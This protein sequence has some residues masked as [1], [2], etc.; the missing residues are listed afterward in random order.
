MHVDVVAHLARALYLI[1]VVH[2]HGHCITIPIPTSK[3][4]PSLRAVQVYSSSQS[5]GYY[6]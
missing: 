2:E 6:G 4:T 5:N 3:L 1:S